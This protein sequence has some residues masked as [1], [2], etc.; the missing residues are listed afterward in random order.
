MAEK[1]ER[2]K[3]K[4]EKGKKGKSRK[5]NSAFPEFRNDKHITSNFQFGNCSIVSFPQIIIYGDKN[6]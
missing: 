1:G 6:P 2:R 5:T 3:G 4:K